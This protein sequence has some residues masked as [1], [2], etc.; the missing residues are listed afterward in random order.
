VGGTAGIGCLLLA[1]GPAYPGGAATEL[2]A[3]AGDW[4]LTQAEDAPGG[5]RWSLG[6][7]SYAGGRLN[8]P[9]DLQM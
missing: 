3:G 9:Y 8:P 2:A 5:I 7:G 4:L 1:L 6:A